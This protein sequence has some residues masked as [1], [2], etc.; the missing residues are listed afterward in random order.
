MR[1]GN[2]SGPPGLGF[3]GAM[4]TEYPFEHRRYDQ[5]EYNTFWAAALDVP[6]SLHTVT[7]R[8]ARSAASAT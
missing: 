7:R 5:L 6:L 2:W 8:Q 1:S 4:I 3:A